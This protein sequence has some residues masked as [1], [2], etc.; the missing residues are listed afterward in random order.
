[1]NSTGQGVI[2]STEPVASEP[3]TLVIAAFKGAVHATEAATDALEH[4][5]DVWD[6][7]SVTEIGHDDYYSYTE[8]RPEMVI[9][10]DGRSEIFWPQT[11]IHHVVT[12]TLPNTNIYIVIGDEPNLRWQ[13][14]CGELLAVINPSSPGLLIS[15]DAVATDVIHTRPFPVY[16]YTT[17]PRIQAATGFELSS[18]E[19]PVNIVGLLQSELEVFEYSSAFMFATIPNY[20]SSDPCPKA[21][22]ALLNMLEDVLDVAI[23]LDELVEN[24]RSW[25]ISADRLASEDEDLAEYVRLRE[26][27]LDAMELPEASGE[28]IA[29]EF[30]RYLRR[31]KP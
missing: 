30:E 7:M 22:L 18:F 15:L 6:V 12:P 8:T 14:F 1:M 31:R 19:G 26:E 10:E 4:L 3:T 28:S 17:D 13:K 11:S 9:T 16:G 21:S 25:Q 27:E 2:V 5:L 29:R 20:I 24:A 23:P